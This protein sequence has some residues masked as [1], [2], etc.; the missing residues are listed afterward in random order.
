MAPPR[1]LVPTATSEPAPTPAV[2]LKP[3]AQKV[4]KCIFLFLL[5]M[6][7]SRGRANRMG[8]VLISAY[9]LRISTARGGVSFV[10]V[11]YHA[12]CMFAPCKCLCIFMF[13]VTELAL[14]PNDKIPI[15]EA[16]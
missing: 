1:E 10:P 11:A 5:R 6:S 7:L 8:Y 13:L 3:A 9:L 12:I 2:T 15:D 4:R 16:R 14:I